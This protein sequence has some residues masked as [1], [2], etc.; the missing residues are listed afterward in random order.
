MPPPL[1]SA[2]RCGA[3]STFLGDDDKVGA[4][5]AESPT[6]AI[7]SDEGLADG[8]LGEE[9][10]A[11]ESGG[12][13]LVMWSVEGVEVVSAVVTLPLPPPEG[14]PPGAARPALSP[15]AVGDDVAGA[16]GAGGAADAPASLGGRAW[17]AP[18]AAPPLTPPSAPVGPT[19]AEGSLS[20]L[21]SASAA[22]TAVRARP[23]SSTGQAPGGSAQVW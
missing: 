20:S 7:I 15:M 17:V 9:E 21:P 14:S 8:A 18:E 12:G 23:Q 5:F 19:T 4:G 22:A 3:P 10:P 2:A 13:L 1:S 11:V 6:L 16:G